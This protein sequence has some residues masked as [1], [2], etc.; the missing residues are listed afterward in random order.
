MELS[1]RGGGSTSIEIKPKVSLKI[2]QQDIDNRSK[3]GRE[4]IKT[5][6]IYAQNIAIT[7]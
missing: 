7:S 6:H 4:W 3:Q 5:Y 1:S 2:E